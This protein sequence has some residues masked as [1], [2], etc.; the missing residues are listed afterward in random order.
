MVA[1]YAFSNLTIVNLVNIKLS[2]FVEDEMDIYIRST[3][4]LSENLLGGLESIKIFRNVF[5]IEKPLVQYSTKNKF[6]SLLSAP[7]RVIRHYKRYKDEFEIKLYGLVR[8]QKYDLFLC[9]YFFNDSIFYINFFSKVNP[10]MEISLYQEG[11]SHWYYTTDELCHVN[12]HAYGVKEKV[13]RFFTMRKLCRRHKKRVNYTQ[14]L[15]GK[16]KL[17]DDLSVKILSLSTV[18]NNLMNIEKYKKLFQCKQDILM[19]YIKRQVYFFVSYPSEKEPNYESRLFRSLT[20]LS[21]TIHMSKVIIRLHPNNTSF[22]KEVSEV[23]SE[24][25]FL[26]GA[27]TD[28]GFLSSE[29]IFYNVDVEKKI[30]ILDSSTSC[31]QP[32]LLF[33]KEPVI[34]SLSK[35]SS[36]YYSDPWYREQTDMYFDYLY[37]LYEDKTRIY[38]PSSIREFNRNL[39]RAYFNLQCADWSQHDNL[40]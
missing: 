20:C 31:A 22:K 19:Y 34:I 37:D 27:Y 16:R 24:Y 12:F 5:Y 6:M 32:K 29:S 35:L 26:N 21:E 30:L 13:R 1:C 3:P 25:E 39:K 2:Y 8:D 7:F 17:I 23:F 33:G 10:K 15:Y 40:L 18:T 9:P 36:R 28:E 4:G 14:Y 38:Q 11:T